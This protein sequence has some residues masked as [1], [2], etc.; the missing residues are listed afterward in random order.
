MENENIKEQVEGAVEKAL[1]GFSDKFKEALNEAVDAAE[2]RILEQVET[3]LEN[4]GNGDG[5]STQTKEGENGD[6]AQR[7]LEA[8]NAEALREAKLARCELLLD[9]RLTEAKLPPELEKPIREQ[10]EGEI[11]E[12]EKLTKMITSQ[13]EAHATFDTSGEVEGAGGTANRTIE[14]VFDEADMRELAFM[15][16]MMGR[17]TFRSLEAAEDDILKELVA[18]NA[19][20]K[21]WVNS[22][23]PVIERR[24][25]VSELTR[26]ILGGDWFNEEIRQTEAL[27]M[28]SVIKNT[29]NIMVAHDYTLA[30]R[31][32]EK[33]ADV[34][35]VDYIDD[36]TMTRL[37]GAD[38]LD[39][40][41]KLA[42]YTEMTLD[43]EEETS[44][45]VKKGNFVEVA[46]E[47][48]LLDKVGFFQSIPRRISDSWYNTL[49]SLVSN[50]F[51]LASGVGP[52][53]S[54]SGALFNA[55][56]VGTAGGHANLDTTALSYASYDAGV[57]AMKKQTNQPLGAGRKLVDMGP[58]HLLVPVDLEPTAN[59]IRNSRFVPGQAGGG[60]SGEFQSVNPYGPDG[61]NRPMVCPVPFFDD[62]NDWAMMAKYRGRSPIK[63]IFPRGQRVPQIFTADQE[64]V[65]TMFTND[66]I[67]FKIRMMTYRFS[68]T[69][70]CAPVADWRLLRKNNV[71]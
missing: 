4:A 64:T 47:D 49:A 16:A 18:G 30:E 38:I 44:V 43:D 23:R 54:D 15:N 26:T 45:F 41:A 12:E 69:E 29:V 53:L 17:T 61:S 31:W 32:Y 71:A 20:H 36:V 27:A 35:E 24:G 48:L 46:I 14:N 63:L 56:A 2:Q 62:A 7:A 42:P 8:A 66:A 51:T 70:D 25:R 37:F 3:K 1:D 58:F 39:T 21:A 60:A 6:E 59:I 67:R 55:T 65:G 34:E 52:T 57:T 68:A 10:F 13:K 5:E 11:F 28:A 33:L 9:R 40:V 22:G 50:V 19:A